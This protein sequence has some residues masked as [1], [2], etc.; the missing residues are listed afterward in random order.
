Q[1]DRGN[2]A[3][4]RIADLAARH[5]LTMTDDLAVRRVDRDRARRPIRP[6]RALAE[7]RH[8]DRAVVLAR[9]EPEPRLLQALDDVL[10]DRHRRR[11]PGRTDAAD[12][13]VALGRMETD[14]IV[15]VLR[16]RTQPDV[17]R[18]YLLGDERR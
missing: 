12:A 9:R 18:C 16:R 1:R 4:E 5:A 17:D 10:R 3:R 7:R 15:T 2:D 8:V 14:L 11:E 13:D 6:L